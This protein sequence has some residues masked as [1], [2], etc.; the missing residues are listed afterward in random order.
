MSDY[1]DLVDE[2]VLCDTCG[3]HVGNLEHGASGYPISC[4]SCEVSDEN[5]G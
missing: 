5:T 4:A 2:G 1:L 3:V